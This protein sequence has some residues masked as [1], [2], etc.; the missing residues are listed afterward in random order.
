MTVCDG[1]GTG[2][3]NIR[4]CSV[5]SDYVRQLKRFLFSAFTSDLTLR[6]NYELMEHGVQCV[7]A[8]VHVV[9]VMFPVNLLTTL[10]QCFDTVGWVIRPVKTVSRITYIVLAQT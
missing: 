1:G 2:R 9:V 10:L 6:R 8:S 5:G 4:F 3:G 7:I